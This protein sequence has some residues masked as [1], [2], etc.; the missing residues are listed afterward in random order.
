VNAQFNLN[1]TNLNPAFTELSGA[2]V[3]G[4]NGG[5]GGTKA[6]GA[7]GNVA[8]LNIGVDG[9]FLDVTVSGNTVTGPLYTSGTLLTWGGQ[10]TVQ[11]GS[12]GGST[13]GRGGAGG[14]ILASTVGSGDVFET[15]GLMLHA[16]AGGSGGIGG[17]TGGSVTNIQLNAPENPE[18]STLVHG[19]ALS[20]LV[21]AGNGGASTGSGPGGL[22]GNISLISENKDVNS[23]INVIQAGNGGAAP[24]GTGGL[25]G[26]VTAVHT[27]GYIGQASDDS[28]NS[29]GAFQTNADSSFFSSLFPYGVPEGV[30]AG[31]GGTGAT[32]GL[33]GSVIGI[34]AA[35]IAAIGAAVNSSGYFA[36]AER[37]ANI[38]AQVIGYDVNGNGLYDHVGSPQTSKVSP[39]DAVAIDG[40]M[41]S[42]M[43]ATGIHVVDPTLLEQFTFVG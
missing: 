34:N 8:N 25:G 32:S 29:F 5:A 42:V 43:P 14:S 40:F 39:A 41:F 26:S 11:A 27:V 13:S 15:Y 37:I 20:T 4:G 3:I 22:G 1:G 33:A 30:F 21:L 12:G 9:G 38:T 17:G 7:G 6:G 36:A 19:D 23:S 10:L 31:R 18:Y 2:T 28:G 35:Q 16:G 24:S